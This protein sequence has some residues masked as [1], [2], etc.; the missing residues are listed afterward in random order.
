MASN[1]VCAVLLLQRSNECVGVDVCNCDRVF[2]RRINERNWIR[3]WQTR[4]YS[5]F[6]QGTC[7]GVLKAPVARFECSEKQRTSNGLTIALDR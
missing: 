6:R 4:A 1:A 3:E 7:C 5:Q 2:A